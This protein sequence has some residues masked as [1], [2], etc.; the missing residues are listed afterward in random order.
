MAIPFAKI[1][2]TRGREPGFGD[3][4]RAGQVRKERAAK[5]LRL[6]RDESRDE[7]L[8]AIA[9]RWSRPED[10]RLF[11]VNLVRKLTNK[12]AQTYRRAPKRVAEGFS[13]EALDALYASMNADV[14]LKRASRLAKLLKVV[15][16]QVGWKES[17]RRPTLGIAAPSV[18]DVVC[19][20]DPED[21]V[22]V[23]VTHPNEDARRVTYSDWTAAS[24]VRRDWRGVPIPVEGNEDGVNPYGRLPFVPCWDRWP[25]DAFFPRDGADL[26]EAQEAVNVGLVN[27][28]RAV[29]LQ[30]HG[31]AWATGLPAGD[32]LRT[33]PDRAVT[34]PENGKFGFAAP[35]APIRDILEAIQFVLRQ[36]AAANDVSAD[37]FDL[38]R[39]AE[40]GAA[41]V[42][43]QQDLREAREDDLALWRQY[44]AQLFDVLRTV[45]NTHAPGTIPEAAT[46]RVDFAEPASALTESERLDNARS[47]VDLGVWSPVDALLSEDPDLGSREDALAELNRRREEAAFLGA[48]LAGP[49]FQEETT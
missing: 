3:L 33:G 11:Q 25:D 18:L 35:N 8:K 48:P 15:L 1:L 37:V 10:F 5:W 4:V 46:I 16:L 6:Y 43:E 9:R 40:S 32:A 28:W 17:E 42:V 41:K 44:E 29:E 14:I 27:L 30:A 26:I 45:V 22:R 19:E 36:T 7:T 20:G 23:I 31:Q 38:D 2:P 34:L 24:Y 21:L 49:A 39:R 13:Q 47:R 12:R